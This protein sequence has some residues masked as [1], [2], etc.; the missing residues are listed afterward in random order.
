[1][2][3]QKQKTRTSI[4]TTNWES[5][6]KLESLMDDFF[7]LKTDEG[8]ILSFTGW[9][10]AMNKYIVLLFYALYVKSDKNKERSRDT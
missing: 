10:V 2:K 7:P 9:W 5:N 6:C 3:V 1:M 4:F 8:W